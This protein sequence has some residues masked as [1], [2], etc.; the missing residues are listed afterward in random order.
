MYVRLFIFS[1]SCC[2]LFMP[3]NGISGGIIKSHPPSVIRSVRVS[4]SKHLS[5]NLKTTEAN[6]MKPYS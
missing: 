5:H 1:F 2:V 3:P 6:L 4:V